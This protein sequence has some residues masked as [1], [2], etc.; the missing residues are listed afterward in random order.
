MT[1]DR[2]NFCLLLLVMHFLSSRFRTAT[3]FLS[4]ARNLR[5][6][7]DDKPTFA[8]AMRYAPLW[9]HMSGE[10]RETYP[11]PGI[12][13]CCPSPRSSGA[14][15]V[16]GGRTLTCAP[17]THAVS[18]R[19]ESNRNRIESESARESNRNESNRNPRANRIGIRAS[20]RISTRIAST[21]NYIYYISPSH[22]YHSRLE[23]THHA[24][25]T[26]RMVCY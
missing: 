14:V 6:E 11:S 19:L 3:D 1:F 17:G 10:W 21:W 16:L 9:V 12:V 2:S 8:H 26:G 22:T 20:A 7:I 18:K 23:S 15:F 25:P 5:G 13:A 24:P 4:A